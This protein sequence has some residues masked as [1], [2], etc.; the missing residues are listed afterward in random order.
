M[1]SPARLTMTFSPAR[2]SLRRMS[3]SLCSV[4]SFTI[5]PP[6]S[7]GSSTAY[8]FSAPVRPTFRRMSISVVTARSGAYLYAVAQRGSRPPTIPSSP[9]RESGFTLTTAPSTS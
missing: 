1:T 5:T 2:M 7:T 3:S 8:G 6:T 4:A 9:C